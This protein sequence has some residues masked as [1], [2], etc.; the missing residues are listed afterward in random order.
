MATYESASKYKEIELFHFGESLY[1][2]KLPEFVEYV[3]KHELVSVLSIN[4]GDL[5]D[6]MA[7]SIIADQP[8]KI[9]VSIDSMVPDR[10]IEPRSAV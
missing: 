9:I 10:L 6:I 1:H 4:P 2:P 7:V 8:S 5:N 3:R